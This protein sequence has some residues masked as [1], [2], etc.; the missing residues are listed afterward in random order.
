MS[1][2]ETGLIGEI[3]KLRLETEAAIRSEFSYY[4]GRRKRFMIATQ[5]V[6]IGG[7]LGVAVGV[8]WPAFHDSNDFRVPYFA[9]LAG[10][11]F[12]LS[13]RIFGF[14]RTWVRYMHAEL[15]LKGTLAELKYDYLRIRHAIGSEEDAQQKY[16]E[17]VDLLK[18]VHSAA[19]KIVRDETASWQS[20]LDQALKALSD[21]LDVT[22]KTTSEARAKAGKAAEDN[23]TAKATGTL[24]LAIK[25]A[26]L[27]TDVSIKTGNQSRNHLS[28]PTKVSFSGL[29][30]GATFVTMTGTL[31]DKSGA[32]VEQTFEIRPGEISDATLSFDV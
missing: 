18:S 12:L 19:T 7:F 24:N 5:I 20:D 31:E 16:G 30:G 9:A 10:G 13:D 6:R 32:R 27:I 4:P 26:K 3:N 15:A 2:Q 8:M 14:S 21:Q 23:A 17:V 28:T 29:A 25:S 22:A 11:L 1:E